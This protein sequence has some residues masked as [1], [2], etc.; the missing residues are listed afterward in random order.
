MSIHI[1]KIEGETEPQR[2]RRAAN[3]II[4]LFERDEILRREVANLLGVPEDA[5][6]YLKDEDSELMESFIKL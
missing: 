6:N 3:D 1:N 4:K 2:L 5:L